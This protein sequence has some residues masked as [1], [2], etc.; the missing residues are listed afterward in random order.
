MAIASAILP[1]GQMYSRGDAEYED[2]RRNAIWNARKPARY[3]AMIA[4]ARSEADVVAAVRYAKQ[5]GLKISVRSGGHSWF[6]NCLRD[7]ALLI[8]LFA[9]QD[10]SVDPA[11]G[12][13]AVGPA[14]QGPAIQ[15][16][17]EQHS[18]FFTTGHAPTVSVGGFLLGGGY[19]WG[20][21][22]FGPACLSIDAI[23]VVLADGELVHASDETHPDLM[24]AA[25]GCG[26]GFFGV[27]TRY[28][29]KT[30]KRPDI[31]RTAL[32]FPREM[33]DE[34]LTWALDNFRDLP[35]EVEPSVKVGFA[36]GY[37]EH[38]V[39]L[40]GVAF[41]GDT[42]RP[43]LLI[44]LEECPLRDRAL[45]VVSGPTDIY[46]L[47]DGADAM[48]QPGLRWEVDGVWVDEPTSELVA[49]AADA[50]DP[51]PSGH[52]FV[53][54]QLWDH[55]PPRDNAC[56]SVQAAVYVSPNAGWM[57]PEDDAANESWVDRSLDA[58][59]EMSRGVQFSDANFAAR[60]DHGLSTANEARV[61]EIRAKYD[62]SGLFNSYLTKENSKGVAR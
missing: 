39:T 21:R 43:E 7:D 41:A 47:Y 28:Y 5:E 2:V 6:G 15:R 56:W 44:A 54:W 34:V 1:D 35:A 61:E 62:P 38:V 58:F 48:N 13:A 14:S 26:P 10:I 45:A 53:F 30:H 51:M 33:R 60:P 25:R 16:E 4:V 50:L 9:F 36:P 20:S 3:P 22:Y 37:D 46:K 11:T 29:L 27:V 24:W 49:V 12:I 32:I 17:L 19:G 8:D 18:L 55:F 40:V 57:Q 59:S 42:S 23:D 31:S 52:A